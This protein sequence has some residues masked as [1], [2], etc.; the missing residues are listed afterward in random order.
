MNPASIFRRD[1]F[2]QLDQAAASVNTVTALDALT[3]MSPEH[4]VAAVGAAFL[5]LCETYRV[6]AQDAFTVIKNVLNGAH[7][8]TAEFNAAR[9]FIENDIVPNA[10]AKRQLA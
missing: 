5:M 3:N 6:Q 2:T 9:M 10:V 4:Q 1:H 7:G 8:P